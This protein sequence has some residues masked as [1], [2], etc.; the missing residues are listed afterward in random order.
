MLPVFC[1]HVK[2]IL[3]CDYFVQDCKKII[4]ELQARLIEEVKQK[5]YIEVKIREEVCQE[6][7]EQLVEIEKNYKLVFIIA[8][9]IMS[10]S[11]KLDSVP[12]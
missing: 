12:K 8:F 7:A 9:K 3:M 6:M 10:I 5:T 4:T 2:G 1:R 11:K